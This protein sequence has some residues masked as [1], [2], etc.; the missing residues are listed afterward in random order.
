MSIC[1]DWLGL[2]F[3]GGVLD[4]IGA[5]IL[6]TILSGKS[7]LFFADGFG[8]LDSLVE[9]DTYVARI[10]DGSEPV[11]ELSIEWSGPSDT[12]ISRMKKK[13]SDQK[14]EVSCGSF[15]SPAAFF[16]PEK[17]RKAYFQLM[18]PSKGE[19]LKGLVIHLP[20]T[21]DEW[22]EQRKS[23]MAND[24]LTHGY[25]SLILMAPFYGKRR[26]PNQSKHFIRTVDLYL[27]A[28]ASTMIE[29]AA[30]VRWARSA[31]PSTPV[32]VA[33]LSYGGAMAA[34]TACLAH[35]PLSIVA[36]VGS[37]SPRVLVTGLLAHQ[38]SWSALMADRPGRTRAAVADELLAVLS[39]RA[40]SSLI[41]PLARRPAA[42]RG[43]LRSA[44]C[45]S[46][47]HDAF[48]IP[49]DSRALHAALRA[50]RRIVGPPPSPAPTPATPPADSLGP[51]LRRS[52]GGAVGAAG[53][54]GAESAD[55]EVDVGG[56]ADGT[57]EV[58]WVAGGH[59]TTI[60]LSARLVNP[61]ILRALAQPALTH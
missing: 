26:A 32:C 4:H 34:C 44:A 59:A 39:S 45:V 6:R 23:L 36:G 55:G 18:K 42:L 21:G 1:P 13:G 9:V 2:S 12:E 38:I 27:K 19:P 40:V 31:F 16:L 48:V 43:G 14:C 17:V 52:G 37:E 50:V 10:V 49:D 11:P 33:G 53:V 54:V 57:V 24:L 46:A 3:W 7:F 8:N 25:A 61:A 58:E 20:M 15:T 41:G 35:D 30:L 29:A 51:R 47:A 22:F 28:A 60:A 5:F 56:D